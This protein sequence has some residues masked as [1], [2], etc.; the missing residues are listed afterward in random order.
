M[1]YIK[2]QAARPEALEFRV[3]AG[4]PNEQQLNKVADFASR[5]FSRRVSGGLNLAVLGNARAQ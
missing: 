4:I 1:S 3:Y 2:P 5:I